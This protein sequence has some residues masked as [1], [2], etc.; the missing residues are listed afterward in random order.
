MEPQ[1]R[2]TLMQAG[3]G[4]LIVGVIATAIAVPLSQR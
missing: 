1:T 3:L 2:R 4:L